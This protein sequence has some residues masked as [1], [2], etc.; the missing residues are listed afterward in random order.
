M[1]RLFTLLIYTVFSSIIYCKADTGFVLQ[2]NLKDGK[3]VE[4]YISDISKVSFDSEIVSIELENEKYE[5]PSSK[6]ENYSFKTI[7]VLNDK[8]EYKE[9]SASQKPELHYFR[10]FDNT[11]WQA[12]YVPFA[13]TYED[14]KDDF[15][16]AKINKINTIDTNNDGVGDEMELTLVKVKEGG[17]TANTPYFIRALSKGK[18][19]ISLDNATLCAAQ[20]NSIVLKHMNITCTFKGTY[21]EI[22]GYDMYT[23]KYYTAD[24]GYL[25]TAED[26]ST[27][28]SSMRWYMNLTTDN[29]SNSVKFRFAIVDSDGTGIGDV[30]GNANDDT[31]YSIDGRVVE[32]EYLKAGIYI[33]GGKK[34]IIR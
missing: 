13:M 2:V 30:Q 22:S 21:S 16:V 4:Y 6:V 9:T 26:S 7:Y 12:L 29:S 33:K 25:Y 11:C 17:I 32:S 8:D 31:T 19:V 24:L 14:W 20:E 10:N 28:L 27:P 3:V 1:K 5:I 15:E 18:K 23:N 34:I